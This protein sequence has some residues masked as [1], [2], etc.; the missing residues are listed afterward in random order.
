VRITVEKAELKTDHDFFNKMDPF[1][2]I[3]VGTLTRR[4]TAKDEAGKLP[5]WN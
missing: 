2:I 5:V 1:V 4:T 3:N